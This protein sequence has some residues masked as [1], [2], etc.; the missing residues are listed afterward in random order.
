MSRSEKMLTIGQTAARCGVAASALR[1]YES[2][3]LISAARASGNQR[4]YA[5]SEIRKISIIKIAQNL[6]LSLKEIEQA[7]STLPNKR[8]PTKRDWEKLSRRWRSDLDQ[9]IDNL[10]ALRDKLSG[11][12]GCGCLSLKLCGLYNQDDCANR[13]GNGARYLLGDKP[14]QGVSEVI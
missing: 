3:G 4:R 8:T 9:R 1:F 14:E 10:A 2:R 11:C 5:R 6:G 13:K 12:I 7:L